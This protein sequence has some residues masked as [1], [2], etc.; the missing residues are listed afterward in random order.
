MATPVFIKEGEEEEGREEE[1]VKVFVKEE[2][3]FSAE[4]E[5]EEAPIKEESGDDEE[6]LPSRRSSRPPLG[7]CVDQASIWI[8]QMDLLGYRSTYLPPVNTRTPTP[9]AAGE[10]EEEW[11]PLLDREGYPPTFIPPIESDEEDESVIKKEKEEEEVFFKKEEDE[12][13]DDTE[14]VPQLD[15]E[16]Y[17]PTFSPPAEL[18][19]DEVVLKEKELDSSPVRLYTPTPAAASPLT[20]EQPYISSSSPYRPPSPFG[21][22]FMSPL[23]GAAGAARLS[24]ELEALGGRGNARA[25]SQR[26]HGRSA[27][28]GAIARARISASHR[29]RAF[30]AEP[31]NSHRGA[32][33]P[34]HHPDDSDARIEPPSPP[35]RIMVLSL[36]PNFGAPSAP[37]RS[38]PYSPPGSVKSEYPSSPPILL[39]FE[40]SPEPVPQL[41]PLSGRVG[42]KRSG[43]GDA[44]GS[45]GGIRKKGRWG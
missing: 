45:G 43:S 26:V 3:S 31:P 6:P 39:L 2:E 1:E 35:R 27:E 22:P 20:A 5:G 28:K 44:S 17:S 30:L 33:T 24:A 36:R 40:G 15:R 7:P 10:D 23:T 41:P 9:E 37:A 13:D 14:W 42:S 25:G 21:D 38:T 8:P 4:E 34:E 18:E 11:V 32:T 16:R 19:E 29:R 12:E